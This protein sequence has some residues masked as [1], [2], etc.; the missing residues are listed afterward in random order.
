MKKI[1]KDTAILT[2]ITIISGML[3]GVAFNITNPI[4][5]ARKMEE[6]AAAFRSIFSQDTQFEDGSALLEKAPEV[7]T[8][9]GCSETI[10][11]VMV[12]KDAAGNVIGYAMSISTNGFGGELVIAYGYGVD[13]TS[14]GID[15]LT[16]SETSGLG[17]RA[18]EPEFKDQFAGKLVEAFSVVKGGAAAD[19]EIN[20]I[21]GAT[22]TSN[23][24]TGA[25]NAGIIFGQYCTENN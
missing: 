20:A 15:I 19:T 7:L 13:G 18:S 10:T 8:A 1:L 22:R 5:Q 24:V 25:V 4:I 12:A 6:K 11:D 14:M 3:L 21:S 17:S 16:S 23:A 2:V 9:A